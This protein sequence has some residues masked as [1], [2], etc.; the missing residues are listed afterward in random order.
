MFKYHGG[1]GHCCRFRFQISSAFA[2]ASITAVTAG[3]SQSQ[4]SDRYHKQ[5]AST[6][7][8]GNEIAKALFDAA[9]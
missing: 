6:A 5:A 1:C 8:A 9:K 4:E 3:T 2:M 7:A